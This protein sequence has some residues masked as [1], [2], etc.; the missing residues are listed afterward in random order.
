MSNDKLYE[1]L[2]SPAI[3]ITNV[4]SYLRGRDNLF[5]KGHY[6]NTSQMKEQIKERKLTASE[7]ATCK[8]Y[9]QELIT[10]MINLQNS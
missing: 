9:F 1:F 5:W 10:W 3:N 8:K 2:E 4:Y 7:I 6:K